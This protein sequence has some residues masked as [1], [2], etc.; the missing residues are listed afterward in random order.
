MNSRFKLII[1]TFSTVLLVLLLLGAAMGRNTSPEDAYRH[2]AVYT[3]VLSRIKSEYVQE[4]DIK[5][6]TLGAMNG[7]LEAIDP[8]AS[9]LSADQYKQYQKNQDPRKANVGL[10]LSRRF[11][12]VGVVSVLPGSSASKA[13]LTTGDILE[14][15]GGVGTRDMPLAY[16]EML[17]TGE[18]GSS[19]EVSVLRL[20]KPEP[21][22]LTLTRAVPRYPAVLSKMLPDQIGLVQIPALDA[23]KVKDVATQLDQ[24]SKQGAKKFILDLRQCAIGKSEDGYALAE[25]FAGAGVLGYLQ[26]QKFPRQDFKSDPAKAQYAK[27]PLAIIINRGTAGAAE[28][29]SAALLDLKRADVVGERTYGDAAMRRPITMDDG[30]AVILSVAK[31]Y[32]PA[33]K[34]IQD[35]GVTPGV[36]VTE[37]EAAIES[38]DD[39]ND[40][41]PPQVEPKKADDDLPLKRAIEVLNKGKAENIDKAAAES[42]ERPATPTPRRE[43]PTTEK[44]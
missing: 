5:N 26:G 34:A 22:K 37:I 10:I 32:S 17:L 39:D 38:D 7:M 19:V 36:Q 27:Q 14:A 33:G 16:A 8:F 13:G 24:L 1:V 20:R 4:P 3:E 42:T 29:A 2:L 35:T 15:I 11:G 30:S 23:G 12:Y 41:A 25:L 18:P 44:K 31:Y 43:V 9:Y 6:V 28:I 21:Q 40:N